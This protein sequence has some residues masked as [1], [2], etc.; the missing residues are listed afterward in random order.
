MVKTFN[1]SWQEKDADYDKAFF[2]MVDIAIRILKQEIYKIN[3][4]AIEY[5]EY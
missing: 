1:P 2:D 5:Y 4:D 3:S